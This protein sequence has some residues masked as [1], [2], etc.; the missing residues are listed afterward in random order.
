MDSNKTVPGPQRQETLSQAQP[1]LRNWTEPRDLEI[2]E[3]SFTLN[4]RHGNAPSSHHST[5][6]PWPWT[7]GEKVVYGLFADGRVES[8]PVGTSPEAIRGM[9]TVAERK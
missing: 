2:D 5:S 8:I 6:G 4:D 3:M 7:E 1:D 9:L